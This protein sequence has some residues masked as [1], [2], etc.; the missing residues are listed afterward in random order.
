ME[1]WQRVRREECEAE[2]RAQ[3]WGS[4]WDDVD[5]VV[6]ALQTHKVK[7]KR[8]GAAEPVFTGGRKDDRLRGDYVSHAFPVLLVE[9]GLPKMRVHDLRHGMAT[10]LLQQGIQTEVIAKVLG[11]ANRAALSASMR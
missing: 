4:W 10:L 5:M 2:E 6:E 7:A 11:H 3:V 8:Y 9:K 1:A